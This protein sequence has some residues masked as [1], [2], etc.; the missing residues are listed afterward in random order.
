VELTFFINAAFWTIDV[1]EL[2]FYFL[3]PVF[4]TAERKLNPLI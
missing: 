3:N 1:T 4:K 2:N